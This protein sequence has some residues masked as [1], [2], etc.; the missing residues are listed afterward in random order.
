MVD[1]YYITTMVNTCEGSEATINDTCTLCVV[2]NAIGLNTC[3]RQ[4]TFLFV[5]LVELVVCLPS[6]AFEKVVHYHG[7]EFLTQLI[8]T[9]GQ[10]EYCILPQSYTVG[11]HGYVLVYSVASMK[12]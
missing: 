8:D 9:A 10:D 12:R 6:P 7:Q 11:V 4:Y 5:K 3:I 2:G 1:Y